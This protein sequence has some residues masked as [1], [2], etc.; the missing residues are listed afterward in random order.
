LGELEGV[1]GVESGE[2]ERYRT[3]AK[4][5]EKVGVEMREDAQSY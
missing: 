1:H 2:E 5:G 4:G 3:F